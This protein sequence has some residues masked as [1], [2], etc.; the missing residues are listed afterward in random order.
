MSEFL[1]LDR[2][3]EAQTK[4]TNR[5][6]FLLVLVGLFGFITLFQLVKLTVLDSGL[7]TT[8]SDENRIVR[9]PIYPSRG[10][11]KLSNGEIV[12]EN[13]VSQALTI[14]PSKTKDIEQ[15]LKELKENLIINEKQLLAYKEKSIDKKSKYERVVIA[16]NLSQ[17]Q[18]ARFSVESDRWPSLSIEARLMRFNL[19]GPI[20]SHVLGYVGQI[21]LEEIEDSINFSYPLSFQI[22]KSG[23]EKSYEE[24]MRGGVGYKT[25]E[26]DVHG[27]EIR[28]LT[29]VIPKKGSDIYLTLDKDLQELARNELAGRKGAIVAL[30]PNT[31]FIKALV[32]GP[33]FNPN[34]F[35][36]T[37]IGDLDIIFNDLESPLFNRAISGSYPPAST[38]K[39][40]IGLLGLKEGEIDWN[41][42]IEDEGFFQLNEEGRKY[43]GWKEEGH[44]QVNL[45]KSIIESSDVFFYQLATQLTVDRIATFLKE[46]GFGLKSGVDL[47][48]EAEGILPDRKWKLGAIGES[49]FVGD[50]VNMGIGQ[51]YISSTPLQLA[52]AV[53]SIATRG[54]IYKPKVV[55]K[56][57]E[58][59]IEKE[60]FL[61]IDSI[62]E[63]DWEKLESSMVSVISDW[64]GTAFNLN[65]I[66]KN[67]I[68]GKTG[69]AQI[70][71]LT[72][73]ELTVKEE[74]E[75][76]RQEV[77]NRDHALFVGYGPIPEPKL[78]VVVIVENG[79]SGSAIAAPIAQRLIDKYLSK[80]N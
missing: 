23:V 73:E 3:K 46:F 62:K 35:N 65:E 48:A 37:E 40:F 10:L 55:A 74:Y 76:I 49:W 1:N 29:R 26:V 70:K 57:N 67:K 8:I 28:E 66:A 47:Y 41:T 54:K 79:E 5:S 32:S 58:D 80:N 36:K 51:G 39:P 43:R 63:S 31:G 12:T 75:D 30:D 59:L 25:I 7:Y 68:A 71:S 22:G 69:T 24:Q 20:F 16:E 19:S 2:E 44:G 18:I 60:I 78:T 27:K 56:V 61:E 50:T 53:S 34:I 13:I 11:I 42:T 14:S 64:R 77:S 33:D 15:T 17:Q 21:S 72:D 45:A 9:V 4:F 6:T 52:L 38:I